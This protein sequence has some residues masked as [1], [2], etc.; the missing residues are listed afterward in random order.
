MRILSIFLTLLICGCTSTSAFMP[1]SNLNADNAAQLIIYTPDTEFNRQNFIRPTIYIDGKQWDKVTIK[2]PLTVF[3]E[4]GPHT[5]GF[6]RAF[7][8]MPTFEAGN[9]EID[10]QA[11][12]TYYLRYSYDFDDHP[13][14]HDQPDTLGA[15]SF[16]LVSREKGE[17]RE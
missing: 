8:L 1:E 13:P 5:I 12:A 10:M 11:N 2:E 4:P 14:V 17:L 6:Q 9:L 15:S 3:L 16:R 7:F